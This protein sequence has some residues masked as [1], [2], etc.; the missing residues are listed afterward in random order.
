[1]KRNKLDRFLIVGVFNTAIDFGVYTVL[2]VLGVSSVVANYPATSLAL[3]F[4][5]VANKRYTFGQSDRTNTRQ[6]ITFLAVTLCG[7]WIL[8]PLIITGLSQ[9]LVSLVHSQVLGAVAAKVCATVV[10]T[11][12]NYILY[13][14]VVFVPAKNDAIPS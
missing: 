13:K 10:T 1:M 2:V 11:I 12:W 9:S 8:Q 5:F 6:I 14:R 3:I 7:L 4:S